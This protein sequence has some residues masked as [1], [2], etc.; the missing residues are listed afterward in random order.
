MA[1]AL[2]AAMLGSHSRSVI[3]SVLR[4][5][6]LSLQSSR[7]EDGHGSIRWGGRSR[8]ELHACGDG[9]LGQAAEV[10]GGGDERSGAGGGGEGHSRPRPLVPGGGNPERVAARA[11]LA[12]CGGVGG[13]GGGREPG[14]EGRSARRL[15]ASERATDGIDTDAGVQ[16]A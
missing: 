2:G 4:G 15:G 7:E 6:C 12:V 3:G 14:G 11:V 1:S 8:D 16:G 10:D 9:P 5:P 13:G